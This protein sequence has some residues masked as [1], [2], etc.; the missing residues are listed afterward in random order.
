MKEFDDEYPEDSREI[1]EIENIEEMVSQYIQDNFS[2]SVIEID[3]KLKRLN[4]KSKIISS[5]SI[6]DESKPQE[7]WLGYDSP[8][9]KIRKNGLWL[10]QLG[11]IENQLTNNDI[12]YLKKLAKK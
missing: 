2:F 10:E 3:N 8:K 4:L 6:S 5:L 12:E 1:E 7:K 9:E 11:N